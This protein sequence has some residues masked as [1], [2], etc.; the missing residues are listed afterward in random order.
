MRGVVSYHIEYLLINELF[1]Y[2]ILSLIDWKR[3]DCEKIDIFV[4][5]IEYVLHKFRGNG[6]AKTKGVASG[7]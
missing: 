1:Y 6:C 3:K 4:R 2:T 5:S 7:E